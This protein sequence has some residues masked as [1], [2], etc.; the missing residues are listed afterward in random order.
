[1]LTFKID[2][3]DNNSMARTGV[4][5]T[6]HGDIQTPSFIVVGT[7]ATVRAVPVEVLSRIGVQAVL[8]NTYHLY[9]QPGADVV[10]AHGGFAPMMNWSGPTFTDSG[11]F[12]VFSLGTAFG[13]HVS[14]VATASGSAISTAQTNTK[15]LATIDDDGVTFKSHKNGSKHRFT[16]ESSMQIQWKLGADIIFA[17]DEC[18]SPT[19]TYEYQV[20]AL[21]RTHAWAER[22][23]VEH[24][25]LDTDNRQSLFGVVQG[26]GFEDLRRLSAR[27]LGAMDFDGYGIGGSFTKDDLATAVRWAT[28]ELPIGKPRHL[29]GIG[30][31][32]DFFLGVEA[33][34]DT[35]DCVTPTRLARHGGFYTFDGK[36]SITNA[37]F[38][39]DMAPL[40]SECDCYV[41]QTYTRAYIAHLF[42]AGEM[43]GAT[44]LSEHNLRFI[45]R[46]VGTIRETLQGGSYYD[47]KEQF[48]SR[49]YV[50][51]Q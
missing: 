36:A 25:R 43:V 37:R 16:P 9:L 29:L 18:T 48:L 26:G 4:L 24:T 49:F 40:D 41:C 21:N 1:M 12:Q 14:K 10:A 33:G 13:N 42:H 27:T 15:K 39:T 22:S 3:F 32:I 20:E 44:L 8:A 2:S 5:S 38:R 28:E 45:V 47:Y 46:L 17:F 23:L 11:G 50:G 19:D 30:E 7:S 6:K 34:I 51:M 35:F 31:P